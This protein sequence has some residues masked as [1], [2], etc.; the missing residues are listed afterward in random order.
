MGLNIIS[1][2]ESAAEPNFRLSGKEIMGARDVTLS[3][4]SSVLSPSPLG[5]STQV[6]GSNNPP[7]NQQSDNNSSLGGDTQGN[8]RDQHHVKEKHIVTSLSPSFT[9]DAK[10]LF[11][12]LT[13]S[14][15][16]LNIE[17]GGRARKTV[18]SLLGIFVNFSHIKNRGRTTEK[19][20]RII[21]KD[22]VEFSEH[23]GMSKELKELLV[24]SGHEALTHFM[25]E[26]NLAC[27]Q[28][29]LGKKTENKLS[30]PQAVQY[31]VNREFCNIRAKDLIERL[32][33]KNLSQFEIQMRFHSFREVFLAQA[34]SVDSGYAPDKYLARSLT[35]S[36]SEVKNDRSNGLNVE[37]AKSPHLLQTVAEIHTPPASSK[38]RGISYEVFERDSDTTVRSRAN[39]IGAEQLASDKSNDD[40]IEE[41]NSG[42]TNH[43][44][45]EIEMDETQ[46]ALVIDTLHSREA[47]RVKI[48]ENNVSELI[49]E[50]IKQFGISGNPH[51]FE[52]KSPVNSGSKP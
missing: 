48:D 6:K 30:N 9:V 24:T 37:N 43:K 46:K 17:E 52:F 5:L 34:S 12:D 36:V 28:M 4:I 47:K 7:S 29:W 20:D 11:N 45:L 35:N 26:F 40:E 13:V 38:T 33:A 42:N 39:E 16:G 8:I 1:V 15:I 2:V 44:L 32:T 21:E 19:I 50:A 41:E 3:S 27:D 14:S 10:K 49:K 18:L 51:Q 22:A 25:G 23:T 31:K